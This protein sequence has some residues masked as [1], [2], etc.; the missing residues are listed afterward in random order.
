M[1][2]NADLAVVGADIII[3][4]CCYWTKLLIFRVSWVFYKG[5]W[6]YVASLVKEGKRKTTIH[7][8]ASLANQ[9]PRLWTIK[10]VYVEMKLTEDDEARVCIGGAKRILGRAAVHGAVEVC[11]NSLQNKFLPFSLC[12]PVQQST[13]YSRPG[14]ERLREHLIL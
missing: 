4:H 14:E 1:I 11:R 13:T 5:S 7:C 10:C 2:C 6:V 8:W 3:R 12:T 9:S